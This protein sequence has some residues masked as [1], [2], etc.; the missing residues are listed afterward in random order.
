[1]QITLAFGSLAGY[2]EGGGLWAWA[3]EQLLGIDALGH[4]VFWLESLAS[5]GDA[6]RDQQRID[7][8]FSRVKVF[9][10]EGRCALLLFDPALSDDDRTL[11]AATA[12][13][14]SKERIREIARSADLLWNVCGGLRRPL[15]SLFRRRAL[16]DWDPGILQAS[17]LSHDLSIHDHHVFFSVGGKLPD[18]DCEVPRLGVSWHTFRPFVY[19]PLW[20]ARPAPEPR[21]PFTSVVHW[22]W[23]ELWLHDRVLSQAKRDGY[24]RYV[25]LPRKAGRPFELA[26]TIYPDD[27]SGDRELLLRNGWTLVDPHD[28]AGTPDAYRR[29]IARSRAE[30]A[31]PKPVYRD[32]KTGWLS[33]RSARYLASGRPVLAEETGFSDHLPTG[34][35]LVAFRNPEEAL[36]GVA[37][38]DANYD[39]HSRAAREIAEEFLDSGRCLPEMLSACQG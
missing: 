6:G 27:G 13:A 7:T 35:G 32:L 2:L 4:D 22:T 5:T 24:L 30:I 28:V 12:Y 9:G 8:F 14:L 15:L 1:M 39:R 10:F 26:T 23:G 19:L 36:E 31:C 21:A 33:D 38:I 17:A 29:Y 3:V 16:I 18:P 34:M 20:P 37:D 11:E 25:A